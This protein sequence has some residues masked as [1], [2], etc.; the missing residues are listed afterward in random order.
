MNIRDN[1]DS[2]YNLLTESEIKAKL[3]NLNEQCDPSCTTDELRQ[4]LANI[5]RLRNFKMLHDH[6]DISGHTHF[7]VLVSAIYDPAFY[8]TPTE[9]Q[10]RGVQLD[11]QTVV[12]SHRYIF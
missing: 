6:S 10:N 2:Y 11:V 1:S 7:L 8:L 12:K 9:L 3:N 5:S 4:Q